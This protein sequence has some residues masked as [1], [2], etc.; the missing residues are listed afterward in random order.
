MS[1]VVRKSKSLITL[2]EGN[3]PSKEEKEKKKRIN[4]NCAFCGG[5]FVLSFFSSSSAEGHI[6]SIIS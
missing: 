6:R 1:T 5:A 3:S 4:L 2:T